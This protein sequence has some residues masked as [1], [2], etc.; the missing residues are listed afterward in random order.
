MVYPDGR[1]VNTPDLSPT[2]FEAHLSYINSCTGLNLAQSEA[3]SLLKKMGNDARPG[4]SRTISDTIIVNVPPTRPDILHECDIMED[5]AIA[6]G[7]NK[8]KKTFP[9]TNTVAVPLPI[10]KLS[11]LVRK[12]CAI[13]GFVE[14]LPLILVSSELDMIA[15]PLSLD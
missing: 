11:D 3:I 4:E 10:N 8:L 7:F 12:E 13:S 9:A 6:Y 5:A 1:T 14:V 2:K 15:S